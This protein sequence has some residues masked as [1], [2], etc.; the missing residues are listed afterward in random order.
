MPL[1]GPPEWHSVPKG[2]VRVKYREPHTGVRGSRVLL[3]DRPVLVD[4]QIDGAKYIRTDGIAE[5]G[6]KLGGHWS[7]NREH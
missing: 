1:H 7:V 2:R 3:A 6:D 4:D 5:L